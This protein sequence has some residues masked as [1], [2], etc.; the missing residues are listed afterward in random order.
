MI[1]MIKQM[2]TGW[3][4][5]FYDTTGCCIDVVGGPWGRVCSEVLLRL[6]AAATGRR[7]LPLFRPGSCSPAG[8]LRN[9]HRN[10]EPVQ[11]PGV[12]IQ[13]IRGRV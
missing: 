6:T 1:A 5:A 12:S 11:R 10:I 2:G 13:V 4:A 8:C 3:V 7:R 9:L